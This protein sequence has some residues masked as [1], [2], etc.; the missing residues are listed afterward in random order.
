MA[1]F[2]PKEASSSPGPPCTS[3]KLP[4]NS[5]PSSWRSC[6]ETRALVLHRKTPLLIKTTY[7]IYWS[8]QFMCSVSYRIIN[9]K[10]GDMM[11]LRWESTWQKSAKLEGGNLCLEMEN[12]RF[13]TLCMKHW[14]EHVCLNYNYKRSWDLHSCQGSILKGWNKV[15]KW[16][17]ERKWNWQFWGIKLARPNL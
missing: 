13:S 5:I 10:A 15:W 9:G 2:F 11:L 6:S 7:H 12:S 1:S 8:M 4:S 3:L 17:R 16:I 14:Y